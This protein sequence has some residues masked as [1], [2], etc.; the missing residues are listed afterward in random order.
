MPYSYID[1]M[2]FVFYQYMTHF[3]VTQIISEHKVVQ[4]FVVY[5][6]W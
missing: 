1:I 5:Q 4:K 2:H 6:F 3:I